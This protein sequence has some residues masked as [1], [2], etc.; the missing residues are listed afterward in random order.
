[1]LECHVKRDVLERSTLRCR[2]KERAML[3]TSVD[4]RDTAPLKEFCPYIDTHGLWLQAQGNH[5]SHR[6]RQAPS[7]QG[8]AT[9]S[10]E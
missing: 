2:A 9:Y 1:M 8:L 3:G 10:R 7:P 6:R 4:A 5:R